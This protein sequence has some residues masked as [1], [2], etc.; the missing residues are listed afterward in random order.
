MHAI[1]IYINIH[2]CTQPAPN[3]FTDVY[4]AAKTQ[5]CNLHTFPCTSAQNALSKVYVTLTAKKN[6]EYTYTH[7]HT[8]TYA[9][10]H[11]CVWMTLSTRWNTD[12]ETHNLYTNMHT[13]THTHVYNCMHIPIHTHMNIHKYVHVRTNA[14]IH[15]YTHTHIQ[16]RLERR[17]GNDYAR[18]WCRH[19]K[20]WTSF[21]FDA[22]K[23]HLAPPIL[24]LH[25][26]NFLRHQ[27]PSTPHPLFPTHPK[28]VCGPLS[29]AIL[30]FHADPTNR[31]YSS[32]KT[33]RNFTIASCVVV[34]II[35]GKQQCSRAPVVDHADV[36]AQEWQKWLF[37]ETRKVNE[38]QP[39]PSTPSTQSRQRGAQTTPAHLHW[40]GAY[41]PTSRPAQAAISRI[42]APNFSLI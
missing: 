22:I 20:P 34:G 41:P 40:C 6:H 15:I 30:Q 42:D 7:I 27:Y 28:T 18:S 1:H 36:I 26:T 8:H 14:H 10:E 23:P 2:I 16:A 13:H 33:L 35:E 19:K 38:K 29:S 37:A 21:S 9:P 5:L 24:G 39:K 25:C 32:G 12:T 3:V 11:T 17:R 4:V 31:V